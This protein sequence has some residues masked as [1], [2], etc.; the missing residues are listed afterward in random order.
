MD[1]SLERLY[2]QRLVGQS[3]ATPQAVVRWLG[4]VQA[5]DYTGAKWALAQRTG[6]VTSA[7]IDTLFNDGKI[8][9]THV[10][11]PTWHFVAPEDIRWLL[12]LTGPRVQAVNAYYYRKFELDGG[13]LQK[14]EALIVKALQGGK[15]LRRTEIGEILKAAG[16]T[17]SGLQLGYILMN[18]ELNAVIC[19][20]ALNGKQHTYALLD[21][22]VPKITSFSREQALAELTRRYFT[23]HGPAQL[24]DFV[25]W[26][27]LTVADAK[28][29]IAAAGL[30]R[31]EQYGKTYWSGKEAAPKNL[32]ASVHL[33]PNYDEYLIAYKDRSAYATSFTITPPAAV[34]DRHILIV[35]GKVAGAWRESVKGKTAT[36][37]VKSLV[38]LGKAEKAELAAAVERYGRFAKVPTELILA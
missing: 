18:A 24:P 19:S 38:A 33:L 29:G 35:N 20:G 2:N 9:R 25:W 36:I 30:E 10:M 22:R 34:F 8:L 7:G 15:Q 32:A 14:S 37:T 28:A 23:N 17:A 6:Q 16:I 13:M 21:E 31:F 4:A 27:G 5:Q 26:S 12:M 11:R 3:L 1:I